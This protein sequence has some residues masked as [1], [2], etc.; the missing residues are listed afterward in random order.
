MSYI[1]T[2]SSPLEGKCTEDVGLG[3]SARVK[4]ESAENVLYVRG[5]PNAV[6]G[7]GHH[8]NV[9]DNTYVHN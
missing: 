8:T 5:L 7:Q 1:N 3:Y 9:D 2:W 4:Y 6:D